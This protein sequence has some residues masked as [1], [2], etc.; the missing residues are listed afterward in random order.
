MRFKQFIVENEATSEQALLKMEKACAPFLAELGSRENVLWRGFNRRFALADDH[1]VPVTKDRK[2]LDTH[3][4]LHFAMDDWFFDTFGFRARSNAVFATG[5]KSM[6][7]IYGKPHAIYPIGKY[8]YVW[9]PVVADPAMIEAEAGKLLKRI[10]NDAGH[11][12][13]P[14]EM[15]DHR[16]EIVIDILSRGRYS[17]TDL[18]AA[19]ASENEIMVHCDKYY[20]FAH[21][22]VVWQEWCKHKETK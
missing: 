8:E 12:F 2:P 11:P 13:T 16:I 10:A 5:S 19:L 9:S 15:Q 22:D 1:I 6:S 17:D 4:E 14:E 3:R 21:D 18:Q 7:T 20:A